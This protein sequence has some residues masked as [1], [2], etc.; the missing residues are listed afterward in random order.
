MS[1]TYNSSELPFRAHLCLTLLGSYLHSCLSS[2]LEQNISSL[3]SYNLKLSKL[4][5]IGCVLNTK[6]FVYSVSCNLYTALWVKL[7]KH[8]IFTLL[9]RNY[10]QIGQ[11]AHGHMTA[12]I[13][14]R[15]KHVSPC[16]WKAEHLL[17]F[18]F[19]FTSHCIST[20][21]GLNHKGNPTLQNHKEMRVYAVFQNEYF[22][23]PPLLYT[24]KFC[25]TF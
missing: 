21:S 24:H 1:W 9:V 18:N 25:C 19:N 15:T 23:V 10:R 7:I 22:E 4:T 20:L 6:C 16:P 14:E 2:V 12:I 13:A 3:C 8:L 11:L 17:L 5:F